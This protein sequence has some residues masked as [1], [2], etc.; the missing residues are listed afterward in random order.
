MEEFNQITLGGMKINRILNIGDGEND[1][2]VCAWRLSPILRRIGQF[3][4][5]NPRTSPPSLYKP[6]NGVTY[7]DNE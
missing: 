5:Y 4:E 2:F 6:P 3:T 1:V 7:K